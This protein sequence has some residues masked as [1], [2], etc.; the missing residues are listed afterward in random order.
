MVQFIKLHIY[1]SFVSE[2]LPQLDEEIGAEL[3]RSVCVFA[4][5]PFVAPSSFTQRIEGVV[6]PA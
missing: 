6:E 3:P 4:S 1:L 2:K 5:D